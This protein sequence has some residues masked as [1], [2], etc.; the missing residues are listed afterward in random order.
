M[1]VSRPTARYTHII[2]LYI[3]TNNQTRDTTGR[4]NKNELD[5]ERCYLRVLIQK[6]IIF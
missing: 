4:V 5:N 2:F 3:Y 6:K 1:R